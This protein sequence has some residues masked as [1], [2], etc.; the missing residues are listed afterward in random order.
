MKEKKD[1][2]NEVKKVLTPFAL[3]PYILS[4]SWT[5]QGMMRHSRYKALLLDFYGTLVKE[6]GEIIHRI[7]NAIAD[8]SAVTN[9]RKQIL[10]RSF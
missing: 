5:K 10:T 7:V 9:D 1:G 6:D 2:I 8:C 4:E 3:K